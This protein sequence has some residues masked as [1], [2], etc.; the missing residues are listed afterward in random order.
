MMPG[1]TFWNENALET[2]TSCPI[3]GSAESEWLYRGIHDKLE[4]VPGV[5]SI[6]RCKE[7]DCTYLTPRP[8]LDSIGKAYATGTYFTHADALKRHADDNG[9]SFIWRLA[10]G[11]LNA[12]YN[13]NR[14][15]A[16]TPGSWLVPLLPPLRLQLD[17]FFRHLPR[18]PTPEARRLL[19]IGCG[20]SVFLL[21]AR[22]A[23][24]D[25]HGIEPD[26]A[27]AAA[28]QAAGLPVMA[29]GFETVGGNG[30]FDIVTSAHVIEHVHDPLALL[31]AMKA[32]LR[33]GG[34]LWL[35]T[36][37]IH[38]IGHLL[39]GAAWL[40]LDPPRHLQVFS[41]SGLNLLLLKAGFEDIRFRRRGRGARSVFE[42]SRGFKR[43]MGEKPPR[44]SHLFVDMLATLSSHYSEELVATARKP[45]E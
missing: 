36:P 12:H 37:N 17:Y 44:F 25:A 33:P 27:A 40:A 30:D 14:K 22:Q 35:A 20:N 23:G 28:A 42:L 2:V 31:I 32:H 3:C 13:A 34:S 43:Q 1:Q 39:F 18:R 26:P 24:W 21:R 7:C 8:A 38:S 16:S 15:P 45:S 5:W 10:N 41:R 19:D 11:Y 6:R 29:S 9:G 4:G